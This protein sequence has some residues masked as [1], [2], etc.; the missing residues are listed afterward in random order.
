M[1]IATGV[2]IVGIGVGD[3]ALE[4]ARIGGAVAV[5]FG[6]ELGG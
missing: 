3:D 5:R 4:N 2:D 6:P 1:P